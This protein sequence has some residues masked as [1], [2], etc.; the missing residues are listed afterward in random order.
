MDQG[1]LVMGLGSWL[2]CSVGMLVFNKLAIQALPTPCTLV[3][4]QFAFTTAAMVVCCYGSLHIGSLCDALRWATVVPF[5]SGMVLTSIIALKYAPMTLFITLR[6]VSPM[7]SLM[8]ERFYPSPI[9][10]SPLAP[11]SLCRDARAGAGRCTSG[12]CPRTTSMACVGR[13]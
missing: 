5:F 10:V 3:G 2:C 4:F 13:C 1:T 12:T 6:V 9:R 8:V 7:I 11:P